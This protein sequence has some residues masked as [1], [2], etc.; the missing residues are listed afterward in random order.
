V[1]ECL[2]NGERA[3]I[4]NHGVLEVAEPGEGLFHRP[5]TLIAPQRAT[6]LGRRLATI[7]AVLC[8]QLNAAPSQLRN[9]S[10]SQSRSAMIRF[11][12]CLGRPGRRLRPTLIVWTIASPK[13]RKGTSQNGLSSDAKG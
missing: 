2:L 8:H 4:A 6:V 7:L 3:V 1:K 10:L 13:I 9:G 12:F 11:G 5:A